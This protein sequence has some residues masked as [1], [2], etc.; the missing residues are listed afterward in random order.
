MT[1]ASCFENN[2]GTV[3]LHGGTVKNITLGAHDFGANSNDRNRQVVTWS[4]ATY[5]DTNITHRD[6]AIFTLQQP[7]IL[8]GTIN[9]SLSRL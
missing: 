6:I 8:N 3:L 7:V 2:K 1:A 5:W 4:S 9:G